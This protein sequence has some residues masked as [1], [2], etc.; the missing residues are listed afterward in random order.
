MPFENPWQQAPQTH[1]R[2]AGVA[3]DIDFEIKGQE[4]Q[5][6]EI[7]GDAG[8]AVMCLGGLLPGIFERH[9]HGLQF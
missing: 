2:K 7:V 6:V 5:F 3:D 4:L 1:Y 9:G 8:L